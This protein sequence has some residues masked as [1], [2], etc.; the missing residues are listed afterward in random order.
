ML[1][2]TLL[3]YASDEQLYSTRADFPNQAK[4]N[5]AGDEKNSPEG[6]GAKGSTR[7][8]LSIRCT[9]KRDVVSTLPPPRNSL[10]N[11]KGPGTP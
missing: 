6:A 4:G 1:I 3:A 5:R 2:V 9:V 11:K 8:T 7:S 10:R